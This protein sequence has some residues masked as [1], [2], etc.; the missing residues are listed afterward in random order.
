MHHLS[1]LAAALSLVAPPHANKTAAPQVKEVHKIWARA[2]HN[3]FTDLVRFKERWYCAFREGSSHV[4]PDGA[5]R[6]ITSADGEAWQPTALL[7]DP[8]ADL[9]DPKLTVTGDGRLMLSAAAAPLSPGASRYRSLVW[10]SMEGRDWSEAAAVA[11][12]DMWLWRVTWRRGIAYGFGYHAVGQ[13]YL[14]L[15]VSRDG[16]AFRAHSNPIL[17]GGSPTESSILFLDDETALCLVRRE[18]AAPTAQLGL[19]RPPYR[20]WEWKDL[21][22]RIGGPHLAS[23][24]DG[25]IVAAGRLYDGRQRTALGWLDPREG[26]F[27]EIL[28]LP[29]GGDNGYPGLVFHDGLLWVSYYSSHEGKAAIYLAKVK[30]PPES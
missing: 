18:G 14:R 5:L 13:G 2:P 12:P 11:D 21:G 24:P 17:D 1:W 8:K 9:R 16:S 10:F 6:V 15:Y 20:A 3:A 26:R 22:V 7:A 30:L 29:S 23:L 27:H 4:S 19:S 25:R 28:T